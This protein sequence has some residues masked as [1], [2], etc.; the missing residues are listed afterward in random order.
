MRVQCVCSS[1]L[2]YRVGITSSKEKVEKKRSERLVRATSRPHHATSPLNFRLS[3][4]LCNSP[5]P[6]FPAAL[7]SASVGANPGETNDTGRAHGGRPAPPGPIFKFSGAGVVR[8]E[9][10]CISPRPIAWAWAWASSCCAC[11]EGGIFCSVFLPD[12]MLLGVALSDALTA[13]QLRCVWCPLRYPLSTDSLTPTGSGGTPAMPGVCDAA[14]AAAASG[15][16]VSD[17]DMCAKISTGAL[18]T[19]T[20]SRAAAHLRASTI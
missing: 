6:P 2:W 16:L 14:A 12:L 4:I 18:G 10:S 3:P 19:M 11:R 5:L 8:R 7:R 9:A 17:M 1:E 20:C 13:S 15:R